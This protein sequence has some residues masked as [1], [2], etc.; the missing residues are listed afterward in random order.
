MS[1]PTKISKAVELAGAGN[2][3][4]N[5]LNQRERKVLQVAE[6]Y[7]PTTPSNWG[8]TPPSTQA[9]ALDALAASGSGSPHAMASA[10]AVYDFSVNGGAIGTI[11]LGVSLP[12]HA[13]VTEVIRDELVACTST[14]STGTIKLV[15]PTDGSLE[16]TALTADGGSPS[17]ASSGGSAVPLK[18]TAAREL[19]ATIATNPITAGRIRYFVRYYISE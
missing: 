14:G 7:Q 11:D 17:L 8:S 19:S 16:Q 3:P 6:E 18:T 4:A 9:A 15:V 12:A 2:Y 10:S 13:I 1:N 5:R